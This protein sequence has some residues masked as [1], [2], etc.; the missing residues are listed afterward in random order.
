MN[1]FGYMEEVLLLFKELLYNLS[2]LELCS[3]LTFCTW[4]VLKLVELIEF[5][6]YDILSIWNIFITSF[7]KRMIEW[8]RYDSFQVKI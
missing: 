5:T 4:C 7:I 2:I 6:S 1:V 8:D 3:T